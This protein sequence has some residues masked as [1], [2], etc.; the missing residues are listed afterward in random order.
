MDPIQTTEYF[1]REYIEKI[2]GLFEPLAKRKLS[3]EECAEYARNMI[4]LE[5]YL[6]ELRKKYGKN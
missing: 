3:D 4:N 6:R 5:L 1:S 2:R